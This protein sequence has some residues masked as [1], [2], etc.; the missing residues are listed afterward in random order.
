MNAHMNRVVV[1]LLSS[2]VVATAVGQ[3]HLR[4]EPGS[5]AE[6]DEYYSNIR[7]V[8]A[9]AYG[10]DVIFRVIMLVSFQPEKVVGIR[11]TSKGYEV[12]AMTPSSTIWDLESVRMRESGQIRAFD[13]DGKPMPPDKDE[14]FKELKRRTP[15]DIHKITTR[16]EAASISAALADRI[17]RIWQTMLLDARHPKDL[18]AGTD[19][20][21]YHFSMWIYGHGV[22]S[23]KVWSPEKGTKTSHLVRLADALSEYGSGKSDAATLT[24]L[25]KPLE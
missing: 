3:E 7:Q 9:A 23:A 13:K 2:I 11:K 12:F 15:S 20:A 21:T 25:L 18:R 17:G 6:A 16:T 24:K 8:F 19:G 14:S 10:D 1:L 4:P 22:V 5:L